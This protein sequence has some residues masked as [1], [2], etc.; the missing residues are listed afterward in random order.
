MSEI[1]IK[2]GN[3]VYVL[4][5]DDDQPNVTRK[6]QRLDTQFIPRLHITERDVITTSSEYRPNV[7]VLRCIL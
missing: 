3:T 1:T 5:E 6:R 4:C 2:Y 7:F